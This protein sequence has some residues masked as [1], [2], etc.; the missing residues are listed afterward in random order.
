M[1]G[2]GYGRCD[3][4]LGG[5]AGHVH[6]DA[7]AVRVPQ[8]NPT[9]AYQPPVWLVHHP[10][11]S[12]RARRFL[13]DARNAL[14]NNVKPA[15]L[16]GALRDRLGAPVRLPDGSAYNHLEEMTN[17]LSALRSVRTALIDRLAHLKRV[18]PRSPVI[19]PLSR[20]T[21]AISELIRRTAEFLNIR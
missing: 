3:G 8:P 9:A 13:E 15:D 20:E 12:P 7:G 18:E 1:T 21:D 14:Q 5:D 19:G 11:L 4:D 16:V 10:A 2:P 6:S 17:A